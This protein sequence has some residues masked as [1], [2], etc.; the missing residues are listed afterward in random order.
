M[1]R[2]AENPLTKAGRESSGMTNH[3]W[4]IQHASTGAYSPDCLK[5]EQRE[6]KAPGP[7]EVLLQTIMLSLDPTSRNWLKLEPA[8]NVFGLAPGS[9][10]VGQAI[11]EVLE[12]GSP[13][14]ARGDLVMGMSGWERYSLVSAERVQK[15]KPDVPLEA[16]LTVFSHIGLAAVTGLI[17]VGGLQSDDVVIVSG[18]A[19]ATGAIAVQIAAAY[20]ARVIGIAGGPDKCRMVVEQFGAEAAIDYKSQ[21][22][23]AELRRLCPYGATL[24]FDNVGGPILDAVLMNLSLNA[25]IA[26]CGQMAL[27]NSDDPHDGQGV[28]NLMQLVFRRVRMEGFIAGEPVERLPEYDAELT[29][30]FAEGKI[31]S[32]PQF[33]TGL[34]NAPEA[35]QLLFNGTNTGKLIIEVSPPPSNSLRSATST[36]N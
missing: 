35:I 16:N 36:L 26:V 19:G 4:I 31:A 12:S 15:V 27:Y 24:Y 5:L 34:E 1:S 14:F 29:R 28:R 7:G 25:R 30:L 6:V 20:G 22:V 11:S 3:A 8:S 18:A 23:E 33:I 32:R 2:L 17:G 21:D 10:M 13:D 9:V